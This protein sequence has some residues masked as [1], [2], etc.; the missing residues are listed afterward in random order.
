MV[1]GIATVV[2][3][4]GSMLVFN[5]EPWG[6]WAALALLGGWVVLI[7][8]SNASQD[9][10]DRAAGR[11]PDTASRKPS[12]LVTLL[13]APLI[14]SSLACFA[15]AQWL[16]HQGAPRDVSQPYSDGAM[17]LLLLFSVVGLTAQAIIS[18]VARHRAQQSKPL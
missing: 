6:P 9:R 15:Y 5:I 16:E 14:V 1:L 17:A 11:V 7:A 13:Q 12:R 18:W 2:A 4:G 3:I 8:L 10:R